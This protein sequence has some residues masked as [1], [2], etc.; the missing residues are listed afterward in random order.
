VA[1]LNCEAAEGVVAGDQR[2]D[3]QLDPR[4]KVGLCVRE[5][6][7]TGVVFFFFGSEGAAGMDEQAVGVDDGGYEATGTL[8]NAARGAEAHGF[9]SWAGMSLSI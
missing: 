2:G 8:P 3:N 5:P 1:E 9:F 7:G 4:P 6:K